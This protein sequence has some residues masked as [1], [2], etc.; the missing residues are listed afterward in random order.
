MFLSILLLFLSILIS[1]VFLTQIDR[2]G[3]CMLYQPESENSLKLVILN[4][5]LTQHLNPKHQRKLI[6]PYTDAIIKNI[7]IYM[8]RLY[9]CKFCKMSIY[10]HLLILKYMFFVFIL[11]ILWTFFFKS[12]VPEHNPENWNNKHKPTRAVILKPIQTKLQIIE[13]LPTRL[14]PNSWCVR[15]PVKIISQYDSRL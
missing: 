7:C 2:C 5:Y 12:R 4:N 8:Y 15:G 11:T 10:T 9:I 3:G 13:L 14:H 1:P 6:N